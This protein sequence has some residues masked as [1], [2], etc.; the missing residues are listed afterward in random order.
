MFASLLCMACSAQNNNFQS[1]DNTLFKQALDS[2]NC[3]LVDVRTPQEFQQSHIPGAINIDVNSPDFEKQIK[4]LPNDKPLA[5]YCRSG[6][7]SKAAAQKLSKWGYK[8]IE[9]NNG[10]I[11]W[12]P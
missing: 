9:L 4:L 1:V 5:I 6:K 3:T 8:G 2:E 7:R 10:F 12:K 11:N